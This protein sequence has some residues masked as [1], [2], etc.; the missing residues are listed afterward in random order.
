MDN[1]SHTL[2]TE[3]RALAASFAGKKVMRIEGYRLDVFEGYV[4][5]QIARIVFSGGSSFDLRNRFET[6]Q[7]PDGLAEDAGT[8]SLGPSK[9]DIWHPEGGVI[10]KISVGETVQRVAIVDDEDRI[11]R[12]GQPVAMIS[13]TQAIAFELESGLLVLDKGEWTD[14][15][16]FVRRG[17]DLD[18]LLTDCSEPWVEGD[19]WSDSYQRRATW[20]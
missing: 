7:L 4:L 10:T 12:N 9:V 20:L 5:H 13:F 17:D 16:M 11:S 15:F 6:L 8:L 14:D 18:A 19:G 1:V 2:E 3:E